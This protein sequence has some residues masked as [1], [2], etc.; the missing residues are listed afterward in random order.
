MILTLRLRLIQQLIPMPGAEILNLRM[1]TRMVSSMVSTGLEV[2]ATTCPGLPVV[3][4]LI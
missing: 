1:L 3:Q 4:V 2:I